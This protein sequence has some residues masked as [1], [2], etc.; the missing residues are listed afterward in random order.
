MELLIILLVFALISQQEYDDLV[1][2]LK[3][4]ILGN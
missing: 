1:K 4:I 3:K 2:E